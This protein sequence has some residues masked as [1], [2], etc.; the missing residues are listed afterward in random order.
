MRK[1]LYLMGSLSD[2]DIEWLIRHGQTRAVEAGAIVVGK[3][4]PIDALLI[5][6]D[7]QLSVRFEDKREL[8]AL[9]PGEVLGEISFV[10]SRPPSATVVAVHESHLL[11]IERERFRGQLAR[12]DGFAARFYRALAVFLADRLRTTTAHLGYGKW[13]SD[14]EATPDAIED[15]AFDEIS[16]ASRRFDDMLRRLRIAA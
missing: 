9:Y 14:A 13:A 2:Q 12:D 1:V 8:A 15:D 4:E 7:G 6:L 11:A 5:L 16:M 10:D 3:G